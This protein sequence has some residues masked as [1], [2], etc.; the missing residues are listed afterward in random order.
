ME[1]DQGRGWLTGLCVSALMV[2]GLLAVW[3]V[4]D[5]ETLYRAFDH[6]GRSVMERV[7]LLFY[8][9]IVPFVWWKCP[10]TGSPLRRRVLCAAV[11]L[12]AVMAI[13]K[14]TD[15]HLVVMQT[16]YP[17]VVANFKGT[18]FKMRFLT[19][20]VVPLGAKAVS[21]SY[22]ILFFGVF[23][24]LLAFYA[25]PLIRGV[26]S[27]HP[28]AWTMGCFGATGVMVQLCDRMPAW[29]RHAR[30]LAKTAEID[31][32]RAL[33]TALEEGGELL[34]AVLALMAIAQAHALY[35]EK[36]QDV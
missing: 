21:L 36:S 35:R 3:L 27:F 20:P 26:F 33:F 4:M 34:L 1:Q 17:D 25:V 30:G 8:G 28:V 7:T 22:F 31:G 18:P 13:V 9:A 15:S 5:P 16:L 10:F 24:G 11:S 2:I 23:A 19:S 6:E 29:I 12:V 32:T 14:Q